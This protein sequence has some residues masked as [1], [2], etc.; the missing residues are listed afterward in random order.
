MI[1]DP[2]LEKTILQRLNGAYPNGIPNLKDI[3]P[4]PHDLKVVCEHVFH[5]RD[6]GWVTFH[7]ASSMNG[8]GCVNIKIT[9]LGKK[10][11]K[12]IS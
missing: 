5:Y 11:L 3:I 10:Y 1:I 9:E 12:E 6:N 2:K 7:D 8:F 4:K